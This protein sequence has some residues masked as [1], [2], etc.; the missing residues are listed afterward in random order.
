MGQESKVS[1]APCYRLDDLGIKAPR[2]R[3]P[4][5]PSGPALGPTQPPTYGYWV[6]P[7]CKAAGAWH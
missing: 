3:N 6:I 2:G 5:H 4:L 1:T 7:G